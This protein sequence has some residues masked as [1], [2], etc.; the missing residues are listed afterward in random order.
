MSNLYN[1]YQ[2][3]NSEATIANTQVYSMYSEGHAGDII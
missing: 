2:C 3:N 1:T